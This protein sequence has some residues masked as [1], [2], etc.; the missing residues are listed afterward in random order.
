MTEPTLRHGAWHARY[1]LEAATGPWLVVYPRGIFKEYSLHV[2]WSWCIVPKVWWFWYCQSKYKLVPGWQGWLVEKSQRPARAVVVGWMQLIGHTWF[3]IRAKSNKRSSK[4]T[5]WQHFI[6]FVYALLCHT[7][8][9]NTVSKPCVR[10]Y[11]QHV[12]LF[13]NVYLHRWDTQ[14]H[15]SIYD[16]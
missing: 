4:F 6:T 14:K 8:I 13:A 10:T 1:G 5:T 2:F 12:R 11:K 15:F 16:R 3:E 9:L 7:L